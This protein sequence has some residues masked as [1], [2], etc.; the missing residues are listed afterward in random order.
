LVTV[1]SRAKAVRLAA[2]DW[3]DKDIAVEVELDRRQVA[4]WRQLF[5][6]GGIAALMRDAPNPGRTRTVTAKV[7]SSIV[8]KTLHDKPIAATHWST[9]TLALQLGLGPRIIRRV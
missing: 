3:K 7:E 4:M 1:S 8:D 5:L 6:D 9:R 2:Q